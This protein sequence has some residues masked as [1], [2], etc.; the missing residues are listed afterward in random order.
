MCTLTGSRTDFASYHL[1]WTLTKKVDARK[2]SI[3]NPVLTLHIGIA[4]FSLD[5][6]VSC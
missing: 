5:K 6:P 2:N 3:L 1:R 4:A